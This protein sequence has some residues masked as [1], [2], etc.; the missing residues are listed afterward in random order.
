MKMISR[1]FM[2]LLIAICIS[3]LAVPPDVFAGSKSSFSS[4]SSS[5][6]PKSS[7]FSSP[8]RSTTSVKQSLNTGG[9]S[10]GRKNTQK[11]SAWSQKSSG[12]KDVKAPAPPVVKKSP[13]T[14]PVAKSTSTVTTPPVV[15]KAPSASQD[16]GKAPVVKQ[17]VAEQGDKRGSPQVQGV[18][19][20][21]KPKDLAGVTGKDFN[22]SLKQRSLAKDIKNRRAKYEKPANTSSVNIDTKSKLF[23]NTVSTPRRTVVEVNVIRDN[24]YHGWQTP[25][26][27]YRYAPTYGM[28]STD[29]LTYALM[30][31]NYDFFYHHYRDAGLNAYRNELKAQAAENAELAAKYKEMES[32]ISEMEKNGVAKNEEYL[33][34]GVSPDVAMAAEIVSQQDEIIDEDKPIIHFASG[35]TLGVYYRTAVTAARIADEIKAPF[36]INAVSTAGSVFNLENFGKDYDIIMTQSD[37]AD[38]YLRTN[39]EAK[40]GNF[41]VM[42]YPEYFQLFVNAQSKI[43]NAG[44][45]D[46]QKTIMIVGPKGSGPEGSWA[47]IKYHASTGWFGEDKYGKINTTNMLY[48]DGLKMVANNPSAVMLYVAGMNNG[49]AKMA[50]EEFAGK[51]KLVPFQE[52]KFLK[53]KDRDEEDVYA[54]ASIPAVY[55]NLQPKG[56]FGTKSVDSLTVMAVMAIS[57]KVI[58]EHPEWEDALKTVVMLTIAEMREYVGYEE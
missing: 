57:E 58:A 19:T 41:Q 28:W 26:W 23:R 37:A 18:A 45:L 46:P 47:N 20:K 12:S 43:E 52:S 10:W 48:E 50:D 56:F 53:A 15:K 6:K 5:F 31:G 8:S 33:P 35:G 54:E 39:K 49:V 14:A 17:P 9:F 42:V 16:K 55:E 4:K 22:T 44:D 40:L 21:I 27:G 24:Y 38:N 51:I 34:E 3:S 7:G 11:A 29:Y 13:S 25:V 2:S 36:R 32:K 30:H 1:I